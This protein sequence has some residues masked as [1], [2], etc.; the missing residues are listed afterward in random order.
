MTA[1]A[2]NKPDCSQGR[3]TACSPWPNHD[4]WRTGYVTRRAA[5][6]FVAVTVCRYSGSAVMMGTLMLLDRILP[7][8]LQTAR[9]CPTQRGQHGATWAAAMVS[10]TVGYESLICAPYFTFSQW[11]HPLSPAATGCGVRG[12]HGGTGPRNRAGRTSAGSGSGMAAL[13]P[14]LVIAAE[15]CRRIRS[16]AVERAHAARP[17]ELSRPTTVMSC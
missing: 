14:I 10:A 1:G 8:C 7:S 12:C 15:R 11:K 3:R 17:P 5:K 16:R 6:S 13:L 4:T 2:P 9:C